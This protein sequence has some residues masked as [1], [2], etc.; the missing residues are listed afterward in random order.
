MKW[1]AFY[2]KRYF[3]LSYAQNLQFT[4]PTVSFLFCLTQVQKE[5]EKAQKEEKKLRE[6]L[7]KHRKQEEWKKKQVLFYLPSD[8]YKSMFS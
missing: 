4:H 8:G 3:K 7:D 6:E 2:L 1:F 5:L